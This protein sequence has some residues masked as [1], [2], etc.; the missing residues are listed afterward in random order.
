[1]SSSVIAAEM[2]A[3]CKD[4]LAEKADFLTL[5]KIFGF[6]KLLDAY[7]AE[8]SKMRSLKKLKNFSMIHRE[9]DKMKALSE[10]PQIFASLRSAIKHDIFLFVEEVNQSFT[11]SLDLSF[12]MPYLEDL[13]E[14]QLALNRKF[15]RQEARLLQSIFSTLLSGL[16]EVLL[17]NLKGSKCRF[18]LAHSKVR[19]MGYLAYYETEVENKDSEHFDSL[20]LLYPKFLESIRKL[21]ALLRSHFAVISH[22]EE[23]NAKIIE[24]LSYLLQN[25]MADI[26]G[27]QDA[28]IVRLTSFVINYAP[29]HV[30]LPEVFSGFEFGSVFGRFAEPLRTLTRMAVDTFSNLQEDLEGFIEHIDGWKLLNFA[31]QRIKTFVASFIGPFRLKSSS[32]LIDFIDKLFERISKQILKGFGAMDKASK[33]TVYS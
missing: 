30:E 16:K 27:L 9:I 26:N 12:S 18:K 4:L 32:A 11:E 1:M 20:Y 6:S 3:L 15:E 33:L 29:L 21:T 10:S 31:A 23:A 14:Q 13:I 25:V 19:L 28:P 17:A 2:D 24:V 7:L 8:A 5:E 22:E